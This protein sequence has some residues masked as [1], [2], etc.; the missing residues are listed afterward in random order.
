[1]NAYTLL[2][3]T[4]LIAGFLLETISDSLNL[5][6]L[7]LK[8]PEE[9]KDVYDPSHYEKSLAYQ[10]EGT[11]FE[12]LRRSFFLIVLLAFIFLGGFNSVDLLAR[13]LAGQLGLGSIGMGVVFLGLLSVL[14]FLAQLPFSLYDT[15]VIEER[16]GFNRTDWKTYVSDV[17]KGSFLGVLFGAPIM[18]GI[19]YFFERFGESAWLY[20]WL[21]FSAVQILLL[22]LAPAVILPLFN[23]FDPLPSNELRSAIERYAHAQNFQLSGIYQMNSSKRSTK[24]NAFFT[25]FGRF[26]R[27]VLFDTLIEKHTTPELVAVVAHEVGHYKRRHIPKI[28]ALSIGS[29]GFLFWFLSFFLNNPDLFVT[30]QMEYVSVHASLV[31]IS[32]L[33]A[34]VLR[35]LSIFGNW[36][37]RKHEFEADRFSSETTRDPVSMVQA[38]KKLSRDN[39]SQ[40]TP[41]PM[42]IILDYT[43]PPVLERIHALRGHSPS[44]RSP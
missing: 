1:M 36:L 43:H 30:F 20:A 25:G 39:L 26:R 23:K 10:A 24:S 42:K 44:E 37:S 40:L 34:P 16:Y 8:I 17:A 32:F 9:F 6:N 15:F 29:T 35:V 5:K 22:F 13:R 2:I 33:Y 7:A 21:G 28:I 41:H 31:F 38:L 11:R 12:I 27:L 4:L 18:A 14:R 19:L 3:I